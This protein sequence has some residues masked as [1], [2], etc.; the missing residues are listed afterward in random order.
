[1]HGVLILDVLWSI[2]KSGKIM[3]FDMD[4][5]STPCVFAML[6]DQ[7]LLWIV[8]APSSVNTALRALLFVGCGMP[9]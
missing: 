2:W 5:M 9:P 6:V 4:L 7:L 8:R 1:M 3:V